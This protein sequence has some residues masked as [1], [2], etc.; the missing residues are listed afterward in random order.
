MDAATGFTD[1]GL[2]T[3]GLSTAGSKIVST[4]GTRLTTLEEDSADRIRNAGD[5]ISAFDFNAKKV[6]P[7]LELRMNHSAHS[8]K[9]LRIPDKVEERDLEKHRYQ[10]SQV[11]T[12]QKVN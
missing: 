10:V 3:Y 1:D 12:I 2:F 9:G 5:P 7:S 11:M 6:M 4:I 8:Y